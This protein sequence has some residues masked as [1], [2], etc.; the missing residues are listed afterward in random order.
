[1]SGET[2]EAQVQD[3]KLQ[4]PVKT[5][6][7]AIVEEEKE[8]QLKE[9]KKDEEKKEEST[10]KA[11]PKKEQAEKAKK[12]PVHKQDFEKDVVYLYQFSRRTPVIPSIEPSC[13]KV[14]SWLKLHGIKYENIDHKMKLRSKR[15]QLP[16]VELNGQEICESNHIIESLSKTFEKQMPGQLTAEQQQ[17]QH[18]MSSMVENH[19]N[20]ALVHWRSKDINSLLKGYKMDLASTIGY[21]LPASVLN[22]VI[23]HTYLRKGQKKMKAQGFGCNTNEEME[24]FG[25]SDMKVLSDMLGEKEFMFGEEPSLL[26]LTVYAHM[27]PIAFVDKEFPCALR[28][29][30]ESDCQN[31]VGLV[32]RMKDRC[33]GDDWAKATGEEQ[34]LNPHIPKPVPAEPEKKEEEKKEE[35]KVEEEEKKEEEKKTEKEEEKKEEEKETADEKKEEKEEKN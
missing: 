29:Y 4:D 34:D 12:F 21:K 7:E 6:K 35:E 14:E 18:A 26:D 1:M 17:I 25:K 2:I 9:E 8:A 31:L 5:D 16:F 3:N 15:G 23:K 19:F 33:W 30:M 10:E 20:W 13:L 24:E 28:D 11:A 27:A 32:N 22:F